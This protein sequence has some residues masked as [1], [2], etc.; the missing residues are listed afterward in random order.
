MSGL[1]V[2]FTRLRFTMASL[3]ITVL[4]NW[5]AG[6]LWRDLLVASLARSGISHDDLANGMTYLLI[7][8]NFL[9]RHPRRL[10][11]QIALSLCTIG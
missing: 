1:V 10:F 4:T 8:T 9:S 5:A 6:G 7:T 2:P 11:D 3:A